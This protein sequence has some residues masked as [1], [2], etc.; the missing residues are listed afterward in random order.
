MLQASKPSVVVM[1]AGA[2]G[3][4]LGGRLAESGLPVT[5]VTRGR[6]HPDA[7]AAQGGLRIVGHGGERIVPVQATA[8]AS[9]VR[10]ADVVIF[11][12]KALGTRQAAR[13]ARHLFA[14]EQTVAVSFQNGLGNE[15]EI[16][17]VIGAERVI[18][19]LTAL[20]ARLEAPGVVR[21]FGNLPSTIGEMAGGPSARATRLAEVFTRHG[22]PT[23]SSPEIMQRKWL[24]LSANVAFSATSGAT[25]LT[26]SEVGAVPELRETAL[27]AMSEAASVAAA[28]GIKISEGERRELFETLLDPAGAGAN[29]TSMYRDLK[30]G[31]P[32]EVDFIY[33]TV[34]ARGAAHGV[35]TP[36]LKTLAALIKGR[37]RRNEQT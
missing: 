35:P 15:D 37:E 23:E 12:C 24:K 4:V 33:G 5:L 26:I 25:G 9:G 31:R 27:A 29:T 10:T 14:D 3:S 13:D 16:S 34:I 36:T 1:G 18:A 8:D 11:L 20:G 22:V 28:C 6:A 32:T 17:A 19:G 7:I 21:D 2:L 30:A